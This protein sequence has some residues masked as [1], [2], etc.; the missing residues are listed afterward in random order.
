MLYD[1]ILRRGMNL[2]QCSERSSVPY[3]TLRQL[4]FGKSD[5]RRCRAM[6][7]RRLSLALGMPMEDILRPYMRWGFDGVPWEA[8]KSRIQHM[9]KWMGDREFIRDAVKNIVPA[10]YFMRGHAAECLY[11]VAM[12]DYVC[13]ENGISP[14]E[15]FEPFRK[16]KFAEP[17]YPADAIMAQTLGIEIGREI[18]ENAIP[19]FVR[20]NIIEGDVRD[21]C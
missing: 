16:M 21:V 18:E 4:A 5:I 19:E 11:L 7:L 6:T 10:Y 1:A 2:H 3:T 8:Y 13:R 15:G 20:H 14:F 12:V 17:I 9:L